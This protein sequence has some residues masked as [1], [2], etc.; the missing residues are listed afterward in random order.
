[1][2]KTLLDVV[3]AFN[4]YSTSK[5]MHW[6]RFFGPPGMYKTE[7]RRVMFRSKLAS[8]HASASDVC[9]DV[10]QLT[11][12]CSK[13]AAAAVA[14]PYMTSLLIAGLDR[15]LHSPP[16]LPNHY[17]SM[18]RPALSKCPSN[19]TRL[20]VISRHQWRCLSIC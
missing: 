18:L 9:D 14:A 17:R 10:I 13:Q 1:V 19:S 20:S 11:L 2:C 12:C 7:F 4:R 3:K 6:P 16:A 8:D 5:N 15:P